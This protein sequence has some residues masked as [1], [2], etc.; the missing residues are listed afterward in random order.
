MCLGLVLGT[1][2]VWQNPV[3]RDVQDWRKTNVNAISG[4][5]WFY[6]CKII[7]DIASD[8]WNSP[9]IIRS[10]WWDRVQRESRSCRTVH[11]YTVS[12]PGGPAVKSR[13]RWATPP[14]PIS[15]W[16]L[17]TCLLTMSMSYREPD[18]F[19]Q[20]AGAIR[21]VQWVFHFPECQRTK[22]CE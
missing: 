20:K 12:D 22:L 7:S 2:E 5:C 15:L 18:W 14:P 6:A 13:Q 16:L 21:T 4:N 19:S 10:S 8:L 1:L 3:D 11:L 17:W 9:V